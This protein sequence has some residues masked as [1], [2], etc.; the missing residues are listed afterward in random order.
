MIVWFLDNAWIF[1]PS[2]LSFGPQVWTNACCSHPLHGMDPSEVDLPQAVSQ[3]T[4][5]GI[6]NAAK[7]KLHHE[8]GLPLSQINV[9]DMTFVTRLHYWAADTV[10]HGPNAPW[11][12]HEIDYVLFW[13]VHQ[14]EATLTIQPDRDEVQDVKWVSPT[15]LETMQSNPN[16]LFSPWFRLICR[17]WLIPIWWKDVS[18][19]VAGQ[20]SDYA[21]IHAF[22]PPPEHFGGAGNAT[23]LF[24][25]G[26][27]T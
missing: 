12:E 24:L 3:G 22:D 25:P 1:S 7:R 23:P 16:L 20:Y 14:A 17:K 6:Q 11:G 8:L 19:T 15:D 4:V 9:D 18:G 26:D 27:E 13:V 10:T 21:T 5:P 2:P